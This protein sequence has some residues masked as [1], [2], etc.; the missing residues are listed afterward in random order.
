MVFEAI[1]TPFDA[2]FSVNHGEL[3]KPI[4]LLIESGVHR[5]IVGGTA[6]EYHALSTAERQ[7]IMTFVA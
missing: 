6:G 5:I 4:D 7:E 2:D 3:S 1:Y